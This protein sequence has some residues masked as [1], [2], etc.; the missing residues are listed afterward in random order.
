MTLTKRKP[1]VAW[2][3]ERPGSKPKAEWEADSIDALVGK[4]RQSLLKGDWERAKKTNWELPIGEGD[5]NLLVVSEKSNMGTFIDIVNRNALEDY[6][7]KFDFIFVSEDAFYD[8]IGKLARLA[9]RLDIGVDIGLKGIEI[10]KDGHL[11]GIWDG[12]R[13]RGH[14]YPR[15]ES[16]LGEKQFI[17]RYVEFYK[18][19][20]EMKIDVL[21]NISEWVVRTQGAFRRELE[22]RGIEIVIDEEKKKQ[23]DSAWGQE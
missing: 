13:G 7:V 20:R 5:G 22:R 6:D 18:A 8:M 17:E 4:L 10:E 3:P 23:A 16:G 2:E 11:K 12:E 9:K 15:F 19:A 14:I 21:V 1:S